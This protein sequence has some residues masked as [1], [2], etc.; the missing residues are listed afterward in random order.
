VLGV[1]L[2]YLLPYVVVSYYDRY[3]IPVLAAKVL[4]VLWAVDRVLSWSRRA[5]RPDSQQGLSQ[6]TAGGRVRVSAAPA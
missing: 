3:A 2:L 5:R 6:R 1:Y 4:M